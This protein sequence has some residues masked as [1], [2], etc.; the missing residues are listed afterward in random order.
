MKTDTL[1]FKDKII[2]NNDIELIF[3]KD[4]IWMYNDNPFPVVKY[5]L[6]NCKDVKSLKLE[7]IDYY[8]DGL[9]IETS[10]ENDKC[11]FETTDMDGVKV[12]IICDKI[13]KEENEYSRQDLVDLIKEISK[14]RDN[15]YETSAFYIKQADNLKQFLNQELD[16][17]TRKIT[18]AAWLKK[19]KKLFLHG[20]QEIINR[21]LD[22]INE[23]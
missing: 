20:Q 23:K 8:K 16:I 19:D 9:I 12:K 17:I 2:R 10:Q 4:A 21:I 1:I 11:V 22:L 18:Q 14:Q 15:E 7:P 13:E 5:T 3:H 6:T